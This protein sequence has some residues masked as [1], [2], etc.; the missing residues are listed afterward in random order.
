VPRPRDDCRALRSPFAPADEILSKRGRRGA[1]TSRRAAAPRSVR[2]E[3]KPL[4]R[5]EFLAT[6]SK[7]ALALGGAANLSWLASCGG[8]RASTAQS[9]QTLGRDLGGT[10]VLPSHDTYEQ[11]RLPFNP[12]FAAKRPLGIVYA[13][14][15]SD[16]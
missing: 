12:R 2:A 16:V 9:L 10:L 8:D 7:A 6:S 1:G 5:R 14:D 3:G 13:A 11:A 15:A 4:K